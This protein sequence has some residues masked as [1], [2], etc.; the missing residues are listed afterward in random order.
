MACE[1]EYSSRDRVWV[2]GCGQSGT[3][4]NPPLHEW[5]GPKREA[6]EYCPWC[7]EQLVVCEEDEEV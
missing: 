2:S 1:Y 4:D 7:G 5:C 6:W 3:Y